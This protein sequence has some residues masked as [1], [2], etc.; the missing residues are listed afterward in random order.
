MKKS[1]AIFFIALFASAAYFFFIDHY[2]MALQGLKVSFNL[3][4][5][6]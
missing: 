3:M 4:P 1:L 6:K 2:L 5:I